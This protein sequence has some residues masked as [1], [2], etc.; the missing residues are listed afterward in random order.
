VL[1]RCF[2]SSFRVAKRVRTETGV[3]TKA[4]SVSSAAVDLARR[5]FDDLGDKTAML[6]GAGKMS[7]LAARHLLGAGVANV[8]VTNRS[9]DRA[10][11][12]ARGFGGTPVPFDQFP[13]Y[14]HLADVVLGSV[15]ATAGYVLG[16]SHLHEVLRARR[17]RPMFFIDLGMPRNFDP[18]INDLQSVYVY[19]IDDLSRVADDHRAEREKEAERA[20]EIVRAEAETFWRTLAA[21]DVTPT[22]VALRGKLDAIRRAELERALASLA[23]VGPDE[24]RVLEAMTQSI[25]NKILHPPTTT[26]KQL[27]LDEEGRDAAEMAE[28][29]HRLF[30]LETTPDDE[31]DDG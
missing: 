2:E 26:L 10:V 23:T 15:T 5:I 18:A 20:E 7:E 21:S 11:Q 9:F 17:R 27:A 14:L 3:A 19:N 22:I 25:V 4:V 29:L 24:R 16:P 6:I 1:Q 13:H 28:V 12:L 31:P 8:I 30:A